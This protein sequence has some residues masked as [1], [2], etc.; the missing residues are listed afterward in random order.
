M[1]AN[2][3]TVVRVKGGNVL[4]S[5]NP[6]TDDWEFKTSVLQDGN[7]VPNVKLLSVA[8][9]AVPSAKPVITIANLVKAFDDVDDTIDVKN[10]TYSYAF[11]TVANKAE[12]PAETKMED[13]NADRKYF[14][15]YTG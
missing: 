9:P 7:S 3:D 2:S 5:N 1:A 4:N 11:S 12:L 13:H 10:L 6:T 8:N 15:G 14:Y